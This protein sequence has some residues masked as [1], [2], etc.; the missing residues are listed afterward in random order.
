A[1]TSH[2]DLIANLRV[3]QPWGY[4]GVSGA[5]HANRANYFGA[6][7]NTLNGHP[8]DRWGWA[9]AGGGELNLPWGDT[10]GFN[11]VYSVGASGYATR[12]GNWQIY[13]ANSVGVGWL[14][15]GIFDSAPN[16]QI[17]L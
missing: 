12:G 3:D 8:D 4:V 16:K 6:T 11:A 5:A 7:N 14:V 9:A 10:I 13:G 17:E 2:P 15:D 1:G